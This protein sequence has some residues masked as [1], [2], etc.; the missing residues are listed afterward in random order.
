MW[1]PSSRQA[2]LWTSPGFSLAR[3][4]SP[5]SD[6]SQTGRSLGLSHLIVA[7]TSVV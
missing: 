7:W 6:L 4:S 1:V 3:L 2:G 5:L